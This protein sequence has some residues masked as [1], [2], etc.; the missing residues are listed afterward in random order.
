MISAHIVASQLKIKK[1]QA[2]EM[3][4]FVGDF[5]SEPAKD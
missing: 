4:D 5:S 2:S 3:Q 1:M